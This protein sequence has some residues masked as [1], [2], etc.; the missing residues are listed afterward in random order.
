MLFMLGQELREN[1]YSETQI[2][3]PKCSWRHLLLNLYHESR[4]QCIPRPRSILSRSPGRCVHSQSWIGTRCITEEVQ[5]TSKNRIRTRSYTHSH[6][7]VTPDSGTDALPNNSERSWVNSVQ[8]VLLM[9]GY[10][11]RPC[12]WASLQSCA[13]DMTMSF[14][15]K[16]SFGQ[17][18]RGKDH[19]RWCS[20]VISGS[21]FRNHIWWCS[22]DHVG[23][24]GSHTSWLS[25]RLYYFSCLL[26]GILARELSNQTDTQIVERQ[27]W[28]TAAG[29]YYSSGE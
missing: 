6:L 7:L 15:C 29:L 8:L 14:F 19:I 28:A 22:R 13:A 3:F 4:N 5:I 25:A 17:P 23:C 1:F 21:K 11:F 2:T 26:S 16:I 10:S 12:S 27:S 20:G 9:P 24:R 18:S